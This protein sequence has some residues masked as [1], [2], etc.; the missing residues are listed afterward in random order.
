MRCSMMQHKKTM[1]LGMSAYACSRRKGQGDRQ[2]E[3]GRSIKL[4]CKHDNRDWVTD[5]V[6]D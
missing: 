2:R 3:R 1:Q 4:K 6:I 5:G